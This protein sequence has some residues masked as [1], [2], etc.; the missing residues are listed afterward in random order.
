MPTPVQDKKRWFTFLF[1]F[2]FCCL[3]ACLRAVGVQVEAK[4]YDLASTL[5]RELANFMRKNGMNFEDDRK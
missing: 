3:H 5:E 2:C 1:C 4:D